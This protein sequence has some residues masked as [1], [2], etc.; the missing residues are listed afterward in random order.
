MPDL[1]VVL[2]IDGDV[3]A[4]P[5][6]PEIVAEDLSEHLI[7]PERIIG[8][9][10]IPTERQKFC[11]CSRGPKDKHVGI[12]KGVTYGWSMCAKCK[13]PV[14]RWHH[15]PY[16]FVSE[17]GDP[18]ANLFINWTPEVTSVHRDWRLK[19]ERKRKQQN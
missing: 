11:D 4:N 14:R 6:D 8:V 3:L 5:E 12:F 13:R 16:N 15:T 7:E 17:Q 18:N 10:P 9:F 1:L 2:R 19:H